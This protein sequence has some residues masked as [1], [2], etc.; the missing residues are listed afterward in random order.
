MG[1]M[2]K[3]MGTTNQNR[4]RNLTQQSSNMHNAGIAEIKSTFQLEQ[5]G[6]DGIPGVCLLASREYGNIIPI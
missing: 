6:F 2:E 3:K 4:T 1:M 5:L